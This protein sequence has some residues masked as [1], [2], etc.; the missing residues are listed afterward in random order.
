MIEKALAAAITNKA[1][2]I[3]KEGELGTVEA[4]PLGALVARL[5]WTLVMVG[6]LALLVFLIWG[7]IDLLSSEGDQEK[8]KNARN[9]ITHALMGMAVLA[10]SFAIVKIL[11]GLFGFDLLNLKWPTS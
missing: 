5:W 10:A 11:D 1:L 3:Y 8:Y 7:G 2:D 6:G 4:N 9:K